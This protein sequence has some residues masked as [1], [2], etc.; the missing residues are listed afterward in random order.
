MN[1]NGRPARDTND[2]FDTSGGGNKNATMVCGQRE[3]V[4]LWP[5]PLDN[6]V[7]TCE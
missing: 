1:V 6:L 2:Q 4:G 3:V 5:R 7:T